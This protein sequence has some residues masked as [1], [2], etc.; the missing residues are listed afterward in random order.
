MEIMMGN[1][2]GIAEPM[3]VES[4]HWPL[5][6]FCDHYFFVLNLKIDLYEY[7]RVQRHNIDD[8]ES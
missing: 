3:G 6:L 4:G 5:S 1:V 8:R 2:F 7:V